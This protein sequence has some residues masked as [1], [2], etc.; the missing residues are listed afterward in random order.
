MSN[1]VNKLAPPYLYVIL[2]TSYPQGQ[3]LDL[4]HACLQ[5]GIKLFQL[6]C[7]DMEENKLVRLGVQIKD[8]IKTAGED[9][10]LIIN[11]KPQVCMTVAADG[12]HLG[13]EDASPI[14]ARDLLGET[15][16]IGATVHNQQ[17]A[18]LIAYDVIDYVGVG[19]VFASP[20]KRGL[21]PLDKLEGLV[22]NI[23]QHSERRVP[24]V[25]IGG[26]KYDNMD[27]LKTSKVDGIAVVAAI[28][29]A[30][31]PE[32]ICRSMLAKMRSW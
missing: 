5:G 23:H 31:M 2:D 16:I 13:Q 18:S 25:A 6:R 19:P 27:S 4:A 11:D 32:E 8:I 1:L 21:S 17:E 26:I 3:L 24:V 7:K 14:E 30:A 10:L 29:D 15:A 12:V 20:T 9:N 22:A 28:A